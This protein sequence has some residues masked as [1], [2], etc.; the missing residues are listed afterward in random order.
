MP[1]EKSVLS[2][3]GLSIRKNKLTSLQRRKIKKDLLVTPWIPKMLKFQKGIPNPPINMNRENSTRVILP[4]YYAAREGFVPEIVKW[5]LFDEIHE[6]VQFKGTLRD[7]QKPMVQKCMTGIQNKG[8]GVLSVPCGYGKTAMALY[9]VA[10]LR[11]RTLIVVHTVSLLNQWIERIEQFLPLASVGQLRC[12]RVEILNDIVIGTVQSISMKD[13]PRKLFETFGLVIVDEIHL[14]CTR[15]FSQA[16]PKIASKYTLGL[17]A[18][19]KRQDRCETI[20]EYYIGDILH[21]E[22][23]PPDEETYVKI[24]KYKINGFEGYYQKNGELSYVR[25]LQAVCRNESRLAAIAQECY[26]LAE[27]GRKL[28]LLGEYIKFLKRIRD[29]IQELIN[30]N[31]QTFTVGMYIGEMNEEDRKKSESNDI[32]VGTYKLASVGMDIQA[33]NTLV[34]VSP[35][36]DIEQSVGRILRQKQDFK[37]LIIDYADQFCCFTNQGRIRERFYRKNGYKLHYFS[38]YDTGE[39]FDHGIKA[40]KKNNKG[41]YDRTQHDKLRYKKCLIVDTDEEDN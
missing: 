10:H 35:R 2:Y 36:K 20:F 3:K 11:V 25:T 9:I 33:L 37:P 41:E 14:M 30:K 12:D 27:S 8:G 15:I 19:P 4:R 16:F 38:M 34:L 24:I 26:N 22:Q 28:L 40:P 13:Y 5:P 1:N 31:N 17:S 7:Y 21:Y 18:T 39:V 29:A 32:I 6:S 23:R